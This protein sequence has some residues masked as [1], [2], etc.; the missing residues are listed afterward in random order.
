METISTS[1]SKKLVLTLMLISFVSSVSAAFYYN[2]GG[3]NSQILESRDS[4]FSTPQFDSQEE[5]LSELVAPFIFIATLLN[6]A[7]SKA[8]TFILAKDDT[9]DYSDPEY[10]GFVP[11]MFPI[12]D[13]RPDTTRYSM[14]MSLAITAS[15]IP[16]PYW[17]IIRGLMA[18]LGIAAAAGIVIVSGYVVYKAL[19]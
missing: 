9:P 8:L 12:K 19:S 6:I 11:Y 16:T 18:S 14:I 3:G 7:L 5:I 2:Q 4:Y 17:D 15:L 13:N 10:R 1:T